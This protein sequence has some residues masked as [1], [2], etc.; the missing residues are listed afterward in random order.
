MS[1][2]PVL[3]AKSWGSLVRAQYRRSSEAS[4]PC[5]FRGFLVA[6]AGTGFGVWSGCGRIRPR[7]ARPRPTTNERGPLSAGLRRAAGGCGARGAEHITEVVV[8]QHCPLVGVRGEDRLD[9]VADE[10]SDTDRVDAGAEHRR[11]GAVS[12]RVEAEPL[13]LLVVRDT[14]LADRFRESLAR[15]V[16][17]R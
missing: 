13:A 7:P 2:A 10:A 1:V 12:E 16:V 15:V 9:P 17:A 11:D 3:H 8:A 4:V 5:G 14:G 6:Q